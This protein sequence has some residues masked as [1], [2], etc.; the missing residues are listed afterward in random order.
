LT[1]PDGDAISARSY[2]SAS[3]GD[4]TLTTSGEFTY[5]PDAGFTGTDSFSYTMADGNGES[6]S[7]TVEIAV[8]SDAVL[9]VELAG[10][11][12]AAGER[13]TVTWKTLSETNNTGFEVQRRIDEGDP[14]EVV[15]TVAG[16]GTTTETQQYRF[17]DVL[18]FTAEGA[19]YRLKQTDADGTTAFSPTVNVRRG[20]GTEVRLAAPFPNPTRQRATVRYVVPEGESRPVRLDVYNLLGQRVATLVNETQNP[21][22]EEIRLDAS[23][24][25]SGSY[26]L[27]M[28]VGETM[29]TERLTVVR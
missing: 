10:L 22:R 20:P 29:R 27:R 4:L 12:A 2:S 16:A 8:A 9:P 23:R 3:N 1:D 14:Y 17:D 28:Q 26:V 25:A 19:T 15:G 18:P 5:T 7:T 21:G 11:E 6:A 24:W 13:V